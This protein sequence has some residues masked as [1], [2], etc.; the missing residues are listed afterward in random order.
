MCAGHYGGNPYKW[1]GGT[2][3]PHIARYMIARGWIFPNE[4]VL[5]AGC[6]TG[7]GSH[8]ISQ[9][10]KKVIGVDVHKE[11]VQ[12]AKDQWQ[13]DNIDYRVLDLGKDELPDVDAAISI[14]VPEHIN[15]LEHFV[16]QLHKHVRRMFL[17]CVPLGGTSYA[18]TKK[19]Q[20]SPAGENNDFNN[21]QHIESIFATDEWKVK[22]S[23]QFGYSGMV[24]FA[25]KDPKRP[26]R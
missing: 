25:R 2:N 22:S 11:V 16:E 4:T 26:K 18:Y 1:D 14:E 6:G 7:Y 17:I 12:V 24:V 10:A 9:L 20:A 8:L 23:W 19:E 15:G 21:T 5:D 13:E 3:A